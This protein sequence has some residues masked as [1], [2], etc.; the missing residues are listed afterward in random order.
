MVNYTNLSTIYIGDILGVSGYVGVTQSGEL[1]LFVKDLHI[2]SRCLREIPKYHSIKDDELKV[3]KRCLYYITNNDALQKII[4]RSDIITFI[5]NWLNT[6]NFYEVQTPI[7]SPTCGGANAKPFITYYNSLKSD[8][9]LRI[10]PELNLKQLIIAGF[11]KVYEIGQQ[12]RN[13]SIDCTHNPE[14]TSL[15]LYQSFADY[16]D[17]IELCET[18]LSEIIYKFN[19]SYIVN[20]SDKIIDFTPPF[21]KIDM[22][23][24]L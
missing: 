5:R 12:F 7:L 23:K 15:E 20:Y 22:I 13:E 17:M 4:N 18:L 16:N 14:F 24:S 19:K 1:S 10:S 2:F 21:T 9:Y 11:P 6:R 8:Y 3:Q